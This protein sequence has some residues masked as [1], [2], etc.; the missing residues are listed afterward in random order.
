M[1]TERQ[2]A[3]AIAWIGSKL[4]AAGIEYETVRLLSPGQTSLPPEWN[5]ANVFESQYA[6]WRVQIEADLTSAQRT[7]ITARVAALDVTDYAGQV[8]TEANSAIAALPKWMLTETYEEHAARIEALPH[9]TL[10]QVWTS[11]KTVLILQQQMMDA[12]RDYLLAQYRADKLR[13]DE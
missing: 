6:G 5:A 8:K 9:T 4:D 7:A 3:A 2:Q 1:L 13:E 10:A 12:M 11:T